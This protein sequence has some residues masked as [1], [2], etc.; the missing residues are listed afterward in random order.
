[1][2]V[3]SYQLLPLSLEYK[4]LVIVPS[5]LVALTFIV[6]LSSVLL[7]LTFVISGISY[8]SVVT[9]IVY[10]FDSLLLLSM[11]LTLI[12]YSVCSFKLL[13]TLLVW[14]SPLSIAYK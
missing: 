5:P 10:G 12:V 11:A 6:I 14:Y 1:L 8:V 4:Y 3:D 2:L 9:C 13:N 7:V